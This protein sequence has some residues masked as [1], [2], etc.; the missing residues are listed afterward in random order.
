MVPYN[1]IES[2]EM[3]FTYAFVLLLI[4]ERRSSWR[5]MSKPVSEVE[6]SK[7]FESEELV[8][9]SARPV[10][11]MLGPLWKLLLVAEPR[12]SIPMIHS[13]RRLLEFIYT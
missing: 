1:G 12:L 6:V 5:N 4:F 9:I 11:L 3:T 7:F 8:L 2:R 10:A 13:A